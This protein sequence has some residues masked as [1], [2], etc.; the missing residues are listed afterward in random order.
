M[1][2]IRMKGGELIK[3][4]YREMHWIYSDWKEGKKN[5]SSGRPAHTSFKVP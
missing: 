2:N 4:T 1:K 3:S 5:F